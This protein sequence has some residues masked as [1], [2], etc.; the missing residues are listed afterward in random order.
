MEIKVKRSA[1]FAPLYELPEDIS[2]VFCI[3]GR[4]G[5]KTYEVSKWVAVS[6]TIRQKRCCILRDEKELIRESI[7]NEVL[8]R[9]DTANAN[10]G[11]TPY[12]DRLDTGI[13]NKR[14]GEMVVL[15]KGFRASSTDKRANL[16]S[17][18][19]ID[20]AVIEEAEDIRDEE[21]FN[22]F[23]DSLRNKGAVT[24]VILN[25]PD[26]NHWI[27]KRYFNTIPIPGEDGYFDIVPKEMK[28][29][30]VIKANYMDNEFLP[31]SI[32][33]RYAGYG[34]PENPLYNK[35]YYLT[36]IMG[37]SS[38]GRKGQILRNVKP[39]TL[40]DYTALPYREVYGQDF[41]TSAPAGLV[42]VKMHRNRVYVRE[43]NYKP[44]NVLELGKL[45]CTLG[46]GPADLI[47]A[48]HA[49]SKA[50]TKLEKGWRPTELFPDDLYKYPAL[51]RGFNVVRCIKGRDSVNYGLDELNQMEIYVV[52][53]S[54]NLWNEV[55]NYVYQIDK[56][57]NSTNDPVDDFNHC[58]VAG[59]M[60]TTDK[61]RVPIEDVTP[62]MMVLTRQG[63]KEV[64]FHFNNGYKYVS[65]YTF[66]W[67]S[68]ESIY[69]TGTS[70]HTVLAYR[71][72][73]PKKRWKKLHHLKTGDFVYLDE[74]RFVRLIS[75]KI[76]RL[77]E[78][79]KT[80]RQRVYNLMV[81]DC[82]EYFANGVLVHN[83]ID[84][85]RYVVSELR[86]PRAQA[87]SSV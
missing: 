75:P 3:G 62:G 35:H 48:D 22:T 74:G 40:A 20:I 82:H 32:V 2:L 28:G 61:G 56:N 49:D 50:C 76:S 36:A 37:Y 63:Y 26:V 10:N 4:G 72:K 71:R 14:T 30:M 13:K 59:T 55:A 18:S 60:I 57:G 43:L 31:P 79:T 38:S 23:Q 70:N 34:D 84:P 8:M 45:Y 11:L 39:I 5:G 6:A 7:L 77:L 21:K 54:T 83:C 44:M 41:G 68:N 9:Y 87:P 69:L 64:L 27:I 52:E 51:T 33:D 24:V 78:R 86:S 42:G 16:K 25:T 81:K 85:L 46:F 58:F 19:N 73:D 47:V 67:G 17:I 66:N 53:E 29:V 1:K 80:T 12:Y 65:T 15:T